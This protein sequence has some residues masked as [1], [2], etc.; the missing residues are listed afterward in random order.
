MK[1]LLFLYSFLFSLD[2]S[3][4]RIKNKTDEFKKLKEKGIVLSYST[5]DYYYF[6][7]KDYAFLIHQTLIK[8]KDL[9]TAF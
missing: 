7:H 4:L 9:G 1:N 5:S 2:I 6:P 8:E 3:F